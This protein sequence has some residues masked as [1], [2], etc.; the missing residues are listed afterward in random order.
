LSSRIGGATTARAS[1]RRTRLSRTSWCSAP[2]KPKMAAYEYTAGRSCKTTGAGAS[3]CCTKGNIIEYPPLPVSCWRPGCHPWRRSPSSIR[4]PCNRPRVPT[5]LGPPK[6]TG[7]Q[8]PGRAAAATP[9]TAR[10]GWRPRR[11]VDNVLSDGRGCGWC[12]S[13][14]RPRNGKPFT[15][16]QPSTVSQVGGAR[17]GHAVEVVA[18]PGTPL[19]VPGIPLMTGTTTTPRKSL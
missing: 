10:P 6:S 13:P 17:A 4:P 2:R 16:V 14:S 9:R 18:G 5:F 15:R 12:S 11:P 7:G 19:A 1:R 8:G 3:K